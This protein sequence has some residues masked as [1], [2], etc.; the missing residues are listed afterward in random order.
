MAI[1]ATAR[2]FWDLSHADGEGQE[3]YLGRVLARR[4][5]AWILLGVVAAAS[6]CVPGGRGHDAPPPDPLGE[7]TVSLMQYTHD[8]VNRMLVVK[9]ES[10]DHVVRV[11]GVEVVSGAF[12]GT[13]LEEYDATVPAHRTLDLRVP[14]GDP[15]CE[16]DLS[17]RDVSV[18]FRV[19][20]HQVVVEQPVGADT[21]AAI[22]RQ[23]CAAH[24]VAEKIP[25]AWESRWR[26]TG[27]GRD[28]VVLASLRVGPVSADTTARLTALDGSVIFVADPARLPLLL[29]PGDTQVL[30]VRFRPNRCDAHV[31]ETS[32]GFQFAVRIR[33][34]GTADDVL[35]PVVPPRAKQQ[36]LSR[37]WQEQCGITR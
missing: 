21:L 20:G 29:A 3:S 27:G 14:L 17:P 26:S 5:R 16:H 28:L 33:I 34:D 32:R 35:V 10:G 31:W 24:R 36:L 8:Q 15:V 22:H 18:E 7:A 11:Q 4:P 2:G 1:V 25:L 30:D 12:T 23:E 9:I 37:A 19:A 13:G 6:A